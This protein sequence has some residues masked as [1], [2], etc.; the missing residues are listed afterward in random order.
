MSFP[1]ARSVTSVKSEF[2]FRR[3]LASNEIWWDYQISLCHLHMKGATRSQWEE[4]AI[5]HLQC[6]KCLYREQCVG[7]MTLQF[8]CWCEGA[9]CIYFPAFLDAFPAFLD[10]F[11]CSQLCF[12]VLGFA[13]HWGADMLSLSGVF[14]LL[15][16]VLIGHSAMS[17]YIS[18]KLNM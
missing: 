16:T 2:N 17:L 8:W 18:N 12:C 7:L 13:T 4:G 6:M 1:S 5:F 15:L 10:A 9:T 14:I 3:H 11:P